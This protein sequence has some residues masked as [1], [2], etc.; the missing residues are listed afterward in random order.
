LTD[1]FSGIA[2]GDMPFFILAQML[3]VW[4]ACRLA[5]WLFATRE[6]SDDKATP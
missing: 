6:Q 4:P 5:G 1:S 3:A 2:M